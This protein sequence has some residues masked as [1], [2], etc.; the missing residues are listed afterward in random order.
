MDINVWNRE[1]K[2]ITDETSDDGLFDEI[3][4]V[5]IYLYD[6]KNIKKGYKTVILRISYFS[7]R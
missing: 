5:R 1:K 2:Y 7:F 4:F 6:I 3:M